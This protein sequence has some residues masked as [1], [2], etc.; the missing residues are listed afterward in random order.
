MERLL[1]RCSAG[2]AVVPLGVAV[3]ALVGV[4]LAAAAAEGENGGS[5]DAPR[6]EAGDTTPL[7]ESGELFSRSSMRRPPVR[8]I[9]NS[10]RK[11]LLR[12]GSNGKSTVK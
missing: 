1:A 7:G 11:K 4:P 8:A 12:E 10:R 5:F 3:A 9:A 2:G 6:G